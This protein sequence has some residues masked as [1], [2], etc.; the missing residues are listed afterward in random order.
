MQ[1]D[2]REPM[3]D[4]A[5]FSASIIDVFTAC[6]AAYRFLEKAKLSTA[7]VNT[8]F[9]EVAC[10]VIRRYVELE[11]QAFCD[12]VADSDAGGDGVPDKE[13]REEKAQRRERRRDFSAE[14]TRDDDDGSESDGGALRDS[15]SRVRDLLASVPKALDGA[16]AAPVRAF[17]VSDQ[18]AVALCNIEE[19][20]FKLD[21]LLSQF[22]ATV[23]Q[24]ARRASHTVSRRESAQAD[25]ASS[26]TTAAAAAAAT[27]AKAQTFEDELVMHKRTAQAEAEKI[28]LAEVTSLVPP[29]MV[30]SIVLL[31]FLLFLVSL[32]SAS[33]V[34]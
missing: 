5:P 20:R 28:I 7:F 12:M 4:D 25:S 22:G 30:F 33:A 18:M 29:L 2:T 31:T 27:K 21:E 23:E 14:L 8:Q 9:A 11:S 24:S 16:K 34:I 13:T 17:T 15:A 6:Q 1:I 3:H 10:N 19:A 26:A 32:D